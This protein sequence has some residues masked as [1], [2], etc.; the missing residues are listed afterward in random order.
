MTFDQLME[1]AVKELQ[2]VDTAP[3]RL[4]APLVYVLETAGGEVLT[5]INDDFQEALA[6]LK[7]SV[8]TKI[9][10]MWKGGAVDVPSYAFRKALQGLNAANA[11]AGI[12]VLTDGGYTVRP[13]ALWL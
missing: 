8:V 6:A 5:V 9:V 12:L 3:E 4:P 7:D 1:N 13:M 2:F 11:Q 10:V